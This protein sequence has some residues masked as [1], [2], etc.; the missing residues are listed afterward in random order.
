M[1]TKFRSISIS[2]LGY[3]HLETFSQPAIH[4]PHPIQ[5]NPSIWYEIHWKCCMIFF[6]SM[7]KW[8]SNSSRDGGMVGWRETLS[9]FRRLFPNCH[10]LL[11]IVG[12]SNPSMWSLDDYKSKSDILGVVVFLYVAVAFCVVAS[13]FHFTDLLNKIWLHVRL[14][15]WLAHY[16]VIIIFRVFCVFFD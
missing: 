11:H 4:P 1:H 3:K 15:V 10:A 7:D 12:C 16:T 13:N 6:C 2:F 8:S 5:T 9:F 14:Y